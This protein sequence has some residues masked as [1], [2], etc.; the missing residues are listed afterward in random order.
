MTIDGRPNVNA[1]FLLEKSEEC[2]EI[3]RQGSE[4]VNRLKAIGDAFMAMAVELQTEAD[5][6]KNE[7]LKRPKE[8]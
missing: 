7:E 8:I 3:S 4:L 2:F 1:Q 6:V 5:R